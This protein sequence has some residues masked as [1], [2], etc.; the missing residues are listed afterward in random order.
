[1]IYKRAMVCQHGAMRGI[2]INLAFS[3]FAL[4]SIHAA[5]ALE[6]DG[7]TPSANISGRT[8]SGDAFDV[9]E[10]GAGV[11]VVNF[12]ATWC[13]PCR[14][15]MPALDSFY[16]AHHS[17]GLEMIAIS[18]DDPGKTAAVKQVAASLHMPVAMARDARIATTYRPSQLP[19]TLVFGRD[20]RLRF[21]SRRTPGLMTPVLLDR[22]VGPLLAETG[23]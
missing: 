20:G 4:L 9:R 22:I 3:V 17:Q 13:L 11:V 15:E 12:W 16:R 7:S 8:L 2:R 6:A 14:A 10:E 18:M 23:R 19:V 21:D 5:T 1:M